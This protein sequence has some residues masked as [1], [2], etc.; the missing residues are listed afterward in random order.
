MIMKGTWGLGRGRVKYNI[1]VD[2]EIIGET[3]TLKLLTQ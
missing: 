3:L 2:I 1:K